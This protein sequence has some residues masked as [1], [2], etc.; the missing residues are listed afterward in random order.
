MVAIKPRW[1]WYVFAR[2]WICIHIHISTQQRK[3]NKGRM[4]WIHPSKTAAIAPL[5][6]RPVSEGL[7]AL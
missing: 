4:Q 3:K 2:G 1:C 7:S 6:F 5:I